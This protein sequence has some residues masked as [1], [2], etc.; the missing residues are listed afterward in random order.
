MEEMGK[1]EGRGT[2]RGRE[3]RVGPQL[4]TLDP[5]VTRTESSSHSV[6]PNL[7]F[8]ITS[9]SAHNFWSSAFFFLPQNIHLTLSNAFWSVSA[10]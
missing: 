8:S 2:V 1:E 3:G 10:T 6:H 9:S 5:P 7:L 4:G